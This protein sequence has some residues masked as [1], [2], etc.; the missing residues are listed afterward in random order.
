MRW[1]ALLCL[2]S[3]AVVPVG[4]V[5]SFISAPAP[6]R[7][8]APPPPTPSQEERACIDAMAEV[9]ASLASEHLTACEF[10]V[11]C[12]HVAPVV[13][14]R[15]GV[16]VNADAFEL[17]R[18]AFAAA[19][20][21]CD[22]VVQVVPRCMA[23]RPACRAGRCVGD[24][25][26]QS[27]DECAERK[28]AWLGKAV[29]R[30]ACSA[31]SQCVALEGGEATS[32]GFF[33][34]SARERDALSLACGVV[35]S[36]LFTVP[37]QTEEVFCV[38]GS[39]ATGRKFTTVVRE[40]QLTRPEFDRRCVIDAFFRV[41]SRQETRRARLSFKSNLGVDGRMRQFEFLEPATLPVEAQAAFAAHLSTC[42]VEPARRKKQAIPIRWTLTILVE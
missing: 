5:S 20:A 31:D 27:P 41:V 29:K 37:A 35:E 18:V 4:V 14:G 28:A 26:S 21:A 9:G 39:C 1:V 11:D 10:D 3:C 23:Q 19:G 2:S 17:N 25:V 34:Q 42:R 32:V 12:R 30:N 36:D 22:G 13:A 16:F 8:S 7:V 38:E 33:R 24:A 6:E 40:P 15:C